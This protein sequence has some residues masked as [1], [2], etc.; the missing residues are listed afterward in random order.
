MPVIPEVSIVRQ[1]KPKFQVNLGY[2][3]GREERRMG[4][5][6]GHGGR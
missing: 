6:R 2:K 5:G 1:E 4:A 3:T